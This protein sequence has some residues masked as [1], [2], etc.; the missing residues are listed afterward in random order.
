MG[1]MCAKAHMCSVLALISCLGL[2]TVCVGTPDST[3]RSPETFEE[4][5]FIRPLPD[6]NVMTHLTMRTTWSAANGKLR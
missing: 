6:G 3:V 1:K 2:A 5:M 4:D